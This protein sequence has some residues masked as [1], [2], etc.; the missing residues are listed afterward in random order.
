[1]SDSSFEAQR[2]HEDPR[3]LVRDYYA[4]QILGE[5]QIPLDVFD[6]PRR[7]TL[8]GELLGTFEQHVLTNLDDELGKNELMGIIRINETGD[9]VEI[10]FRHGTRGGA[11]P[12]ELVKI[13]LRAL[14]NPF[15]DLIFWHTHPVAV[16]GVNEG[17]LAELFKIK[18]GTK[19][20][21]DFLNRFFSNVD[22]P[23][24]IS[25]DDAMVWL[26][27]TRNLIFAA[28]PSEEGLSGKGLKSRLSVDSTIDHMTDGYFAERDKVDYVQQMRIMAGQHGYGLY[29][30]LPKIPDTGFVA[31]EFK[32]GLPLKKLEFDNLR[33][34]AGMV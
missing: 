6:L 22:F 26:L 4:K 12:W 16:K 8:P 30:A 31:G 33:E 11:H 18:S 17:K 14:S 1:M 3:I 24:L 23:A 10:P 32:E 34:V 25:S 27:G 29:Y 28:M 7:V 2:F 19:E 15:P 13:H 21:A 9:R 20:D 5:R